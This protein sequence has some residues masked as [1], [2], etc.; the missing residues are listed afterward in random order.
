MRR[1]VGILT[2]TLVSFC[3]FPLV[4]GAAE[5]QEKKIV[6]KLGDVLAPDHPN[7]KAY[8]YFAEKVKER[9]KGRVEVQ[10]FHSGQLGQAKDLYLG[11]QTGSIEMAKVALAF[12]G[13]WIPE[14]K[15]FDLPYLFNDH[16]EVWRVFR[17]DVGKRFFTEIFPRQNLIG[18]MWVDEGKRSIYA[19]K[20][21]RKPE[22][23][24]GLKIR[25]QPSEIHIQAMNEMGGIATP[26]AYGEVYMA[27]QQRVVDGAENAPVALVSSKHYE[28]AK[29]YSL[30][31]QFWLIATVFASKK[32]WDSLPKDVQGQITDAAQEAERYLYETYIAE[33]NQ[34]IDWLKEKG[35]QIITDVDKAAFE[36]R[37]QPVYDTFTKKYGK[38]VLEQV[39]AAIRA[40]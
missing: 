36:K 6:A 12:V 10:V 21:V 26:T 8:Y 32:W 5:A 4:L 3:I 29:V 38:E 14:V 22:D 1:I 39:R 16:N 34:A 24:K 9:T 33:E 23:L 18:I 19:N 30:T 37:V 27:I 2:Y 20:P 11:L 13:E 28:V 17:S 31:E 7:T 25:V 35:V 40:R 15:I